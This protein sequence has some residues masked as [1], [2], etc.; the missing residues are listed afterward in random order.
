[1][2]TAEPTRHHHHDLVYG[3]NARPPLPQTLFAALQHMLAMFVGII[4]PPLIIANALGLSGEQTR[5]IVS[6]SLL[7]SGIASFIQTRRFGP[8]GSGL[9]SV[10]GTSFNFLGPIIAS[11]LALK[12]AAMPNE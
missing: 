2:D 1:M 6:M 11:G 10:Q 12:Q 5:Y 7:M 8:I 4:T 9:L 3:L